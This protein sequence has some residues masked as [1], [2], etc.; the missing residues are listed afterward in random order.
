MQ[1]PVAKKLP[2]WHTIMKDCGGAEA[3]DNAY[4]TITKGTARLALSA[5]RYQNSQDAYHNYMYAEAELNDL[6]EG[7]KHVNPRDFR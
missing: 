5:L 3:E 4:V 1:F 6:L 2:D 7:L